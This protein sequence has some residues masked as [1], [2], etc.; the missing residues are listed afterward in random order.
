MRT[1]PWPKEVE[2]YLRRAY[3]QGLALQ[4]AARHLDRKM[5]A[6]KQNASCLGLKPSPFGQGAGQGDLAAAIADYLGGEPPY[7]RE[8]ILEPPEVQVEEEL[9]PEALVA[10]REFLTGR[11]GVMEMALRLEALQRKSQEP[12]LRP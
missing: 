8:G 1:D 2:R 7:E 12:V 5:D 9:P 11:L 10:L 4:R 6:T 3:S